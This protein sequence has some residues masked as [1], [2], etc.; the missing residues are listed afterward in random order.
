LL[1][2][3]EVISRQG[4]QGGKPHFLRFWGD[5][6]MYEIGKYYRKN[7]GGIEIRKSIERKIQ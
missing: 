6:E 4:L 3:G 2:N 1:A 7:I 5:V